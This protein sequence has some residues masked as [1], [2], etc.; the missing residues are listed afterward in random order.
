MKQV[1]IG[2][3]YTLS[4]ITTEQGRTRKLVTVAVLAVAVVVSAITAAYALSANTTETYAYLPEHSVY[5]YDTAGEYAWASREVDTLAVAG[6]IKGGGTHLFYPGNAITRA[7]FIVML[8]RAYGMSEALDNGQVNSNG[9]FVDVP[10]SAYYSKA[11][12]A[13]KAFGIAAGTATGESSNA[14]L[15]AQRSNWATVR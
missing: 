4:I 14:R 13:A 7:D 3:E 5:F 10:S 11:V 15:T 12:I 8:D 1:Y 9:S 2:G 6:V